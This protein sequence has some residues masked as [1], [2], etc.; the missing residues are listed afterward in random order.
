ML[1]ARLGLGYRFRR[2]ARVHPEIGV[3]SVYENDLR[4]Q[5]V[6]Y[7]NP[8][9]CSPTGCGWFSTPASFKTVSVGTYRLSLQFFAGIA[10]DLG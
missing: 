3:W 9:D 10:F 8:G 7:F 1:G 5:S 4:R 6:R 2:G